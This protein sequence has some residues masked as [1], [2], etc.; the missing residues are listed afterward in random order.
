MNEDLKRYKEKIN[1]TRLQ[2]SNSEERLVAEN[3]TIENLE[4]QLYSAHS[5][6]GIPHNESIVSKETRSS[7]EVTSVL[8]DDVANL[9]YLNYLQIFLV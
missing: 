5:S 8:I 4:L 9:T 2:R 3:S 1:S 7:V 6:L